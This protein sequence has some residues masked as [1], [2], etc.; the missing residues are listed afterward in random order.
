M[1]SHAD[2]VVVLLRSEPQRA[3]ADFLHDFQESGHSRIAEMRDSAA[4]PIRNR[5][6]DLLAKEVGIGGAAIAVT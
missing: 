2:G 4:S 6:S 1:R 3:R 5:A